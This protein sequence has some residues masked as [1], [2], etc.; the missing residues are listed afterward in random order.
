VVVENLESLLMKV[1]AVVCCC[2][3]VDI[4][5]TEDKHNGLGFLVFTPL[6]TQ[7]R[8]LIILQAEH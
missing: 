4:R 1:A 6:C 3:D 7:R 8:P 5:L 2:A